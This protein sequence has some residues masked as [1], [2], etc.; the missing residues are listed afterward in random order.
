MVDCNTKNKMYN[1]GFDNM[2]ENIMIINAWSLLKSFGDK[3]GVDL[4][5]S[6]ASPLNRQDSLLYLVKNLFLKKSES[7]LILF[8]FLKGKIKQER[9]P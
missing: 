2:T 6:H 9:K 1:G 4:H 5:F 7:P 8:Y 3:M